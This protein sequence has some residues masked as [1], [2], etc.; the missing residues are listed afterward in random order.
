MICKKKIREKQSILF[1][2]LYKLK[3]LIFAEKIKGFDK[4]ILVN[5]CHFALRNDYLL[6]CSSII[7][8]SF[9]YLVGTW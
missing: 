8:L 2:V 7:C 6:D 3:E 1:A 9:G 4:R 5:R